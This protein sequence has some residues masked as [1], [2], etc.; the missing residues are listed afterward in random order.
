MRCHGT[1]LVDLETRRPVDLLP[2]RTAASLA[3]WLRAHPGVEIISRD[4]AGAYAEGAR[5]GA[6]AAVQIADRWHMLKNLTEAVEGVLRRQHGALRAR[7]EAV[8]ADALAPDPTGTPR[9]EPAP[10]PAP[11]SPMTR[12][13]RAAQQQE[14]RR[15][16]RLARYEEVLSLH[17]EGVGLREIAHRL[18]LGRGTVR[19]F[20]RAGS[21][22]ERVTGTRRTTLLAP[23]E[24]YLRER[25]M[26]GCQNATQ[27]WREI[28]A[29]GY[30]GAVRRVWT[31]LTQWRQEPGKPG[32]PGQRQTPCP[33]QPKPVLRL[34]SA[35]Q[36]TWLLLHEPEYLDAEEQAFL[37]HLGLVA[38]EILRVQEVARSFQALVA[39]QDV[40][41][42]E[43]WLH[44]AEQSGFP[45][46]CGF[47]AG[48]RNDRAAVE[49]ALRLAWSQGQ[50]EG[51]VNRLNSV[52]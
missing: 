32:R 10:S 1:I 40:I 45:E 43:S 31:V 41:G 27:L 29:Q 8:A 51:Q 9:T 50:T 52:S 26:A 23:F 44:A 21:F 7:A 34:F 2:D 39:S 11:P 17:R 5:Q 35:R 19:R 24:A 47:A 22:P 30:T 38:P 12:P 33:K 28:R 18:H 15:S 20:V 14:A 3:A 49:A 25:W 46:L 16:Q 4:R 36:T 13:S 6:P 37:L 42:L 48:I